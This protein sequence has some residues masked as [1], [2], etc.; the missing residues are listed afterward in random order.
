MLDIHSTQKLYLCML[1]HDP[2]S[3]KEMKYLFS[4]YLL[5]VEILNEDKRFA[6]NGILIASAEDVRIQ[7]NVDLLLVHLCVIPAFQ[8]MFSLLI[9]WITNQIGNVLGNRYYTQYISV[10]LISWNL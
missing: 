7:L 8:E 3:K 2:S 4:T 6:M 10:L 9:H 1:E 5:C